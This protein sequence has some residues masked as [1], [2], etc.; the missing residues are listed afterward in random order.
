M[1]PT[2]PPPGTRGTRLERVL[3]GSLE[4]V[5]RYLTEPQLLAE[6]LAVSRIDL[7][8][9]GRVE[10]RPLRTEGTEQRPSGST[11]RGVVTRFEPPRLLSFTWGDESTPHSEVTLELTPQGQRVRLT[12]THWRAPLQ[13]SA[14]A[15]GGSDGLLEALAALLD[16]ALAGRR[17]RA[18][19]ASRGRQRVL[20]SRRPR[21][22]ARW[23]PAVRAA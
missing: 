19:V 8:E 16:G 18:R 11:V 1:S 20:T 9:G 23:H 5:W 2:V 3:P 15:S 14:S 21:L 10:L 4:H 22:V 17:M 7:R 13:A 6:W 12:V